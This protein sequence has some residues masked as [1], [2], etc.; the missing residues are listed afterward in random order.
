MVFMDIVKK[1]GLN[2]MQLE[3]IKTLSLWWKIYPDLKP[4]NAL[5]WL[6]QEGIKIAH[7]QSGYRAWRRFSHGSNSEPAKNASLHPKKW[8]GICEEQNVFE[9][10]FEADRLSAAFSG[11]G[12]HAGLAGVCGN[13]PDYDNCKL[14]LECH[15]YGAEG[16][17]EKM[18]IEEKIQ[19]NKIST[20]DIPELMQWLLSSNPEEAKALQNSLN[21]EA[22]LKD[23][24]RERLRELENQQPLDSNLILRL[25]ALREM[26]R[27]YGIE[28]LKPQDQ[29]NSSREIFNHFHQQLE[30][31]K[32]EQFIIVLLD[33]KHRYLAEEDV[34]KGILNKSL[35]H[36]RE[37]FASA[38]EHRAAALICVHN[39]PSGDSEPSQEDFRITE[40]LV[41]VG[42]LVGIPVV[43]HVIVGGDN[44][45]SFA[46]K[47]LL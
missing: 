47:G 24:S 22:P 9:N 6:W 25:E 18:A 41:E 36:P 10:A 31:Q 30:R 16:N 2:P 27:N 33:N 17:S 35:V 8:L 14:R 11:E 38:I 44:Y 43:D 34:T 45:T 21:A 46:D 15:W 3:S 40:R 7:S 4:W 29:F 28:K 26:C 13:L 5:K 39:H 42:K 19:R 1:T 37:V 32:Q 20:A 12:S 23:W